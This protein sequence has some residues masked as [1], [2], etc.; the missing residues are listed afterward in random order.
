MLRFLRRLWAWILRLM[1]RSPRVAASAAAPERQV[2][3]LDYEGCL[4]ALIEQVEAG[5]SWASL[6]AD[7]NSATGECGAVGGLVS[8]F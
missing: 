1:G 5:G 2:E 3:D 6:Q 8:N 4:F 7:F